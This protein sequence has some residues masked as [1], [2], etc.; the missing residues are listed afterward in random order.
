MKLKYYK[1]DD[2]LVMNF[3]SKAVEDSY[4]VESAI[5]EVDKENN[6][7]SL[8]IL[9]ASNFFNTA[10]KELPIGIKQKFFSA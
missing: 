2:I 8:E 10:S 4:E 9:H 3:S 5:L 1:K 7:V 6:P